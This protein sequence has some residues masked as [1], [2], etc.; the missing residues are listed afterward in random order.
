[1]KEYIEMKVKLTEEV[2][3]VYHIG[4]Y[5]KVAYATIFKAN[6]TTKVGEKWET[7]KLSTLIPVDYNP[8][9]PV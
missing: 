8:T 1:M 6:A 5:G 3:R 4:L 2:V 9:L 7:V